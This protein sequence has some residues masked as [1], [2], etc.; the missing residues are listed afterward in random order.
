MCRDSRW[1][2][3]TGSFFASNPPTRCLIPLPPHSFSRR[4]S[5]ERYLKLRTNC[6]IGL[7]VLSAAAL[8]ACRQDMHNQ[9]KY[10]P[11]RPSSFFGDGRS[12]RP[13]IAGTVARG[14]L[15]DDIAFYTGKGADNQPV[16]TFPFAITKAD[17]QRG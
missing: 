9:P 13:L 6:K 12:E 1:R 14:H 10:I 3:A 2:R 8:G 11:L 16:N 5:P 17:I 4:W 7:I 15:N